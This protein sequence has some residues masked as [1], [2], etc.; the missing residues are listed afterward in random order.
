MKPLTP[1]SPSRI[2]WETQML[3]AL[4]EVGELCNGDA[5]AIAEAQADRVDR[6]YGAGMAPADAADQL[7]A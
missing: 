1:Q 7:L 4:C 5:Q 3:H 2:A 6:L